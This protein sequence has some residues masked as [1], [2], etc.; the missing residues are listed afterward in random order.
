MNE[1]LAAKD[2]IT[3]WIGPIDNL[4]SE[5]K[6]LDSKNAGKIT[7]DEFCTWVTNSNL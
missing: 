1:F 6:N 4:E 3:K 5:F 7:F 2:K